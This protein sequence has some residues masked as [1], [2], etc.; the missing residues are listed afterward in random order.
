MPQT[1]FERENLGRAYPLV[2]STNHSWVFPTLADAS[3]TVRPSAR[4]THGMHRIN[5]FAVGQLSPAQATLLNADGDK[6][7]IAMTCTAVPLR[8]EV[9]L[10]T[11]GENLPRYTEVDA[12]V[13]LLSQF[14]S[15]VFGMSNAAVTIA[16]SAAKWEGYI[17]LGDYSELP[18]SPTMLSPTPYLEPARITNTVEEAAANG[19]TFVYNK[20][21]TQYSPPDGCGGTA[22]SVDFQTGDYVLVDQPIVGEFRISGGHSTRVQQDIDT[23]VITISADGGGGE[24][25]R[26]CSPIGPAPGLDDSDTSPRCDEV[27]RAINGIGGPII[28][29]SALNSVE[30]GRYPTQHR[31]I[32]APVGV[33][34]ANCPA[35]V[36][37]VP[38]EYL[39]TNPDDVP[40]GDDGQPLP[41]PPGPP[42]QGAGYLAVTSTTTT[43]AEAVSNMCRWEVA[44]GQ[45]EVAAYPCLSPNGCQS[46]ADAPLAAED[47]AYT[48]CEFISDSDG[49][50]ILN[51]MFLADAPFSAWDRIGNVSLLTA[52]VDIPALSLPVARLS[53][54]GSGASLIQRMIAITSNST[55]VLYFECRVVQGTAEIAIGTENNFF[56][57]SRLSLS[58]TSHGNWAEVSIGPLVYATGPLRLVI[59]AGPSTIL[60]IGQFALV[61]QQ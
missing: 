29:I 16:T 45:W 59:T 34:S 1:E 20:V 54:T 51:P 53:P 58:P 21:L 10:F 23:R 52:D 2:D 9:L 19:K 33:D 49:V 4:Y 38:V 57:A 35:V 56:A 40:C 28:N 5:I 31:I 18:V 50:F 43:T 14:T 55:Y 27:L 12:K 41:P 44:D 42:N 39:P 61:R 48:P 46:P 37:P 13:V 32:I 8:S 11:F 17:V 22:E 26:I 47:V 36:E 24:A 25:G 30:I 3:I 15:V 6:Y 60:D 7:F